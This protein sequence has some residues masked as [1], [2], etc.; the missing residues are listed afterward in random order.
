MGPLPLPPSDDEILKI[1]NAGATEEVS[2]S[3]KKY[4]WEDY[5]F[6]WKSGVEGD[7]GH[8]GYHGLKGEMYDNFIRLGALKD[9]SMSLKRVPEEGGNYYVL[10][11]TVIA[12][13]DG[14]YELLSGDIKPVTLLINKI[15]TDAGTRSVHLTKGPNS[16]LLIYDRACETFLIF[17]DGSKQAPA[18]QVVTMKWY[19]DYGVLPF[20]VMG[21]QLTSGLFAFESA[22]G[23]KSLAFSAYGKVSAW[24]NGVK[25]EAV[26][27]KSDE[28]G[29]TEYIVRSK[30]PK[31][32]A[33]QVVFSIEYK[34]GYCGGG[35][36][37][38]YI[39]QTCGKGEI[40]L[41]DWSETDGL[42]S[43]SGGA[44]YSKTIKIDDEDLKYNT[45]IDLGDLVSS[46]ELFV[47]G[48]SAGIKLSPPWTFD[49]SGLVMKG[50]N[51]V[52]VLVYNTLANNYVA[53]PTRYRGSIKSGL[54][55][56]VKL[57]TVKR[58]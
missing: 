19:R 43:Y 6:S 40:S 47:N 17:R 12:S 56:P 50:D 48:K 51:Q 45:I 35:T 2:V 13:W 32:G 39:R 46:A 55:G 3:G 21:N 15:K 22:P 38:Q 42:K 26:A 41:G 5:S 33:S 27:G 7:Y 18:R 14:A 11:T 30:N 54:I 28:D 24:I 29:L 4:R 9:V 58:E 23:L 8:Q 1:V 44:W 34:P 36:I 10:L 52:E 31:S 37:P 16:V 20:S 49:I 25:S 53:I 57:Q